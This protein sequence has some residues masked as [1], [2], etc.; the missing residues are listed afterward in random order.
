M[1]RKKFRN[2]I[3]VDPY[4]IIAVLLAFIEYELQSE[5]KMRNVYIVYVFLR[6]V[7]GHSEVPDDLTGI[8]DLSLVYI[9]IR[10]VFS[11]VSIIIVSFSIKR[12][13]SDSP[14]AESVPSA[15]FH[16]SAFDRDYRS[17]DGAHQIVTEMIAAVAVASLRSEIVVMAVAVPGG[18]R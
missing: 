3:Y 5:V 2:G 8:Y 18:D 16:I 4:L 14:S 6:A 13:Y 1:G 12:T 11:E 9:L 10:I 15:G 7:S 17:S